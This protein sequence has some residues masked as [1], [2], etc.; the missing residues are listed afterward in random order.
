MDD[1]Q[2]QELYE[3][4]LTANTGPCEVSDWSEWSICSHP[5]T[6]ADVRDKPYQWR[7]RQVTKRGDIGLA[8]PPLYD[9]RDCT[10]APPPCAAQDCVMGEWSEWAACSGDGGTPRCGSG[11]TFRHRNIKTAPS[12]VGALACGPTVE[13]RACTRNDCTVGCRTEPWGAWSECTAECGGGRRV[14]TR[15]VHEPT[16]FGA[17]PPCGRED[18]DTHPREEA[19]CN[20]HPCGNDCVLGPWERYGECTGPCGSD[21]GSQLFIRPVVL[22]ASAGRPPCP[23]STSPQRAEYRPCTTAPCLTQPPEAGGDDGEPAPTTQPPTE[24]VQPPPDPPAQ[25]PPG[26]SGPTEPPTAPTTTA[27]STTASTT[28]PPA[29]PAA[30]AAIPEPPPAPWGVIG[31]ILG[32]LA[33]LALAL[34]FS[35]R[36][37]G[38]GG[39]GLGGDGLAV[40]ANAGRFG[41]RGML[42]W[43]A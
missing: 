23:A 10:P 4:S 7:V 20:T 16:T 22:Q 40:S 3:R 29:S 6:P 39:G 28:A 11:V 2:W 27:T 26:P 34:L 41:L 9:R 35:R 37:G 1:E 12:G 8:C 42:R 36:D 32:V 43:K 15:V 25:P 38:D 17:Q 31:G 24:P 18:M 14:R 21:R 30:A 5:C 19:D 33:L 13:F